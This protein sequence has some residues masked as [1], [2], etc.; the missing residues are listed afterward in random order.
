VLEE[1]TAGLTTMMP[2]DVAIVARGIANMSDNAA[3]RR[4]RVIIETKI[5]PTIYGDFTDQARRY[6]TGALPTSRAAEQV[7]NSGTQ[8]PLY[9]MTGTVKALAKLRDI[10][11]LT[12]EQIRTLL[13]YSHIDEWSLVLSATKPLDISVDRRDRVGLLLRIDGLLFGLYRNDEAVRK[14]LNQ[15]TVDFEGSP[16]DYMLKGRLRHLYNIAD[17]IQGLSDTSL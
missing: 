1:S 7:P 5:G 12:D 15:P 3:Q 17:Y 14:W 16:L 8:S 4:G 2:V 6:F 13:G 9:R 10:W 11:G